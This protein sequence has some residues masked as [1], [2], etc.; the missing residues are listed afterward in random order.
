MCCL[1]GA[2]WI[3]LVKAKWQ[4]EAGSTRVCHCLQFSRLSDDGSVTKRALM[5]CMFKVCLPYMHPVSMS[6]RTS[7]CTWWELAE[8]KL[9]FIIS[10][11]ALM[12]SPPARPPASV[13]YPR[14][15]CPA[16]CSSGQCS[17]MVQQEAAGSQTGRESAGYLWDT[18][19]ISCC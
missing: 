2:L 4:H 8:S 12:L 11:D 6:K 5:Q 18:D 16:A 9:T 15:V 13:N 1:A 7:A 17:H 10:A 14:S 19:Y 3:W